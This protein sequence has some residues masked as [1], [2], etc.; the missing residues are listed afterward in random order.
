[1]QLSVF[2]NISSTFGDENKIQEL[3]LELTKNKDLVAKAKVLESQGAKGAF[4][5]LDI[6]NGDGNIKELLDKA[7][8]EIFTEEMGNIKNGYKL[9][10]NFFST[11][12]SSQAR[13]LGIVVPL[14]D[15]S[16]DPSSPEYL[17]DSDGEPLKKNMQY[18][19]KNGVFSKYPPTTTSSGAVNAVFGQITLDPNNLRSSLLTGGGGQFAP[20]S[21]GLQ[22][23]DRNS[24]ANDVAQTI[25][26]FFD[27]AKA[28]NQ[29][30][31][32]ILPPSVNTFQDFAD[33]IDLQGSTRGM[34]KPVQQRAQRVI[35][36][37]KQ[38]G[39]IQ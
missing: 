7:I 10:T 20:Y 28:Q 18:T 32:G 38:M 35:R 39:R 21:P 33:Y 9:P 36:I 13:K 29:V 26:T 34:S 3:I 19:H 11:A 27:A 24:T 12:S 4:N 37:L 1:M 15:T 17:L 2:D 23:I 5:D 22:G 6:T 25:V 31:P 14:K 30:T 16:S 8:N